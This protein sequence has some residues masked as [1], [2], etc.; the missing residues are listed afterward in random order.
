[1]SKSEF[2]FFRIF[3]LILIVILIA[4]FFGPSSKTNAQTTVCDTA[5]SQSIEVQSGLISAQT[6]T[7][8]KAISNV[9]CVEAERAIIPQF[10]LQNYT[11]M[12][13][14]YFDQAK[15]TYNKITLLGDQIQSVD[16]APINLLSF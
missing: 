6:L 4:A 3:I 5:G 10:A 14:L 9:S 8:F 7:S 11:E 13:T 12:K 1:M 16:N 2:S 15:S